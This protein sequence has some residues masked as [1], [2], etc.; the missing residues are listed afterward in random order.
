MDNALKAWQ[1]KY[2]PAETTQ[3]EKAQ[4][5]LDQWKQRYSPANAPEKPAPKAAAAGAFLATA[6]VGENARETLRNTETGKLLKNAIGTAEREVVRSGGTRESEEFLTRRKDAYDQWKKEQI[7]KVSDLWAQYADEHAKF[8]FARVDSQKGKEKMERMA[9]LRDQLKLHLGIDDEQ[10]DDILDTY[11]LTP[12]EELNYLAGKVLTG[13]ADRAQGSAQM[14]H[15]LFYDDLAILGSLVDTTTGGRTNAEEKLQEVADRSFDIDVFGADKLRE[16]N[17]Q[18]YA[19]KYIPKTTQFLG[20]LAESAGGMLPA[21]ATG[22]AAGMLGLSAKAAQALNYL[23][24]GSGAAGNAAKQAL[25]EGADMRDAVQYGLYSGMLEVLTESMFAGIAGMNESALMD[26]I[27]DKLSKNGTLR[28]LMDTLG[29]G[30][31]EGVVAFLEPYIRRA[32]IDPEAAPATARE[33]LEAAASGVALSAIMNGAAVATSG[34]AAVFGSQKGTQE[35]MILQD[36][37]GRVEE[38]TVKDVLRKPPATKEQEKTAVQPAAPQEEEIPKME[39]AGPEAFEP[40]PRVNRQPTEELPRMELAG[41]EDFEPAPKAERQATEEIP[42]MEL[43]GPEAF[44]TEK[45]NAAG[46]AQREKAR[47]IGDMLEGTERT[48]Y[49]PRELGV[50][51]GGDAALVTLLTDQQVKQIGLEDATRIAEEAGYTPVFYSGLMVMEDGQISRWAKS[52]KRLYIQADSAMQSAANIANDAVKSLKTVAKQAENKYTERKNVKEKT[53]NA[54]NTEVYLR[55]GSERTGSADTGRTVPA[56]EGRTGQTPR[57]SEQSRAADRGAA[58]LTYGK[59]VSTASLGL[60]DGVTDDSLRVVTGGDT[61]ATR[62]AKAI[63]ASHGLRVTLFAGNDLKIHEPLGDID[64]RGAIVG[65]RVYIRVDHPDYT[66]DQIMRHEAGHAR[67]ARGEIDPN[68]VRERIEREYGT[69]NLDELAELYA[70]AYEGSGMTAAEIWEEVI[71]DSLGDMNIFDKKD[72]AEKVS[73]WLGEIRQ[74]AVAEGKETT[75]GPPNG[76]Q[77]HDYD[78]IANG[79]VKY[80]LKH[81]QELM[82]KAMQINEISQNVPIAVIKRA[83][84]AR[85]A[86]ADIFNDPELADSLGLPPDIIGNTYIPNGSYSGTEENTTVCIRSIAADA[87]MDAV[88]EKLGRPLTVEDTIAISQEYW[89]YTDKP[90]CLYCYVAMDRKAHRE[91]MGS[92]MDQRDMVLEALRNGESRE[93]VYEKFLDGRKDTG[94]KQKRFAMWVRNAD[95]DKITRADL[96]S[97]ANMEKALERNPAL[98]EQIN[99]ALKY[100]QN[101]SWAKKRVAYSAYNGHIL[102]WKKRRIDSLNSNYGLRMYSFSD[103]SPAFILENMQMVT[104]AAVRNLKVLAYTKELDF[105]RI[106]AKTGMNINISVFGYDDGNGGVAMDAMQGA[107]WA[108]AQ[109]LREQYKNVG[110][111]FVATNDAQVNWALEQDWV[112]VVIPFHMVRTGTKVADHFGWKNYTAMSADTKTKAFDSAKDTAHILPPVHQNSKAKY[113]QACKDNN[114]TPRFNDWVDHPNYMKLVKETRQSEAETKP[115]QPVFDVDAAKASIEDMRKRGGYYTPIGGSE[116]NMRYIAGEIAESI[117]GK[118]KFSRKLPAKSDSTPQE[119]IPDNSME[120]TDDLVEYVRKRNEGDATR[121]VT[122]ELLAENMSN[123]QE[124][125]T[126][127]PT[128]QRLGVKV[129]NSIGQYKNVDQMLANARAHKTLVRERRKYEERMK[130]TAKEKN[131]ARGIADGI[132][133]ISEINPAWDRKVIEA[134]SEWYM[135]ERNF[136]E[137]YITQVKHAVKRDVDEATDAIFDGIDDS[138]VDHALVLNHRTATRNMTKMFGAEKGAQINRWLF[139]PVTQN[140]AERIRFINRQFDKVRTFEDQQG[141]QRP[142]NK[143]ERELVQRVIEYRV[144]AEAV[145]KLKNAKDIKDAAYNLMRGEDIGDLGLEFGLTFEEQTLTRN[146][147]KWLETQDMLETQDS[148]IIYNA[149]DTYAELFDTYYDAI[150]EFLA[151]HG[152]QPIGFIKGYVPHLQPEKNQNMLQKTLQSMGINVDAVSIP[153]SIA[154][155]TGDYKPNKKWN[156]YFLHRNSGVTQYDIVEAF[157]SYV[158]NMADVLYHT[159]DIMRIRSAVRYFRREYSPE[160]IRSAIDWAESLRNFSHDDKVSF[161]LDEGIISSPKISKEDAKESLAEF[162]EKQYGRI[163]ET[164]KYNNLVT[165]LDNYA[166]ILAG[167]QSVADRGSEYTLGRKILNVGNKVTRVFSRANVAGNISSALNNSAQLPVILAENGIKNSTAAFWDV[168]S[169]KLRKAAWAEE[170]DF[171]TGKRGVN[172]IVTTPGEMTLNVFY[173]PMEWVDSLLSTMAVRGAYLR[174]IQQGM[175]HEAAMRFADKYAAEV[176]ADRSKG[177]KPLAFD[178]KNP[179]SAMVHLFQVEALNSWEHIAQDLPRDIKRIA[180]DRGKKK[181]AAALAGVLTKMLV[182]AFIMNR[183]AEKLYGGTPAMFDIFGLTANF[184]ASGEG[185]STN[186]FL[187]AMI[188]KVLL[189]LFGETLFDEE[190][191]WSLMRE[192]EFDFGAGL[193]DLTYNIS[194]E[195]PFVRNLSALLGLGDETLPLPDV[196]TPAKDV[197]AGIKDRDVLAALDAAVKGLG[198]IIPGGRQAVKTYT[199]IQTAARGGKMFGFGENKKLQYPVSRTPGKVA[200]AVIFGPSALDS[201]QSYYASGNKTLT[202]K[203]TVA[204]E[205][206]VDNGVDEEEAYEVIYATKGENVKEID[207]MQI[208]SAPDD[209]D[210]ALKYEAMKTMVSDATGYRLDVLQEYGVSADQY[211][212][213]RSAML[214]EAEARIAELPEEERPETARISQEDAAKVL[215][216]ASGIDKNTKAII[217][218][219][220]DAGWSYKSNPYST[221]SGKAA[222][223]RHDQIKSEAEEIPKMELAGLD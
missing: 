216:A 3:N 63:A 18:L 137:L 203:E 29:E 93:A 65:N 55:E 122:P 213:L 182:Y 58:A 100:A 131:F 220:I 112:D 154:G 50:E 26:D 120:T 204:W 89:K 121:R 9:A 22:N 215:K 106:F 16:Y 11:K 46:E 87:L 192:N 42:K 45:T 176:M 97:Y 185:L 132:Y 90:E 158:A 221:T 217:W 5:A 164:H 208:M 4:T 127:G 161:L 10:L 179:L 105:V 140:E 180:A 60:V 66:A 130:A 119:N 94:D 59:T 92:Y 133:N 174:G 148:T 41:P 6:N 48:R 125:F 40:A 38:S 146:Y 17:E 181:A 34:P 2:K 116:E 183:L 73:E 114:L 19:D 110:C 207:A 51:Q 191:E 78:D 71:C 171:L 86:V 101:A 53:T 166:N 200:K 70:E 76:G 20:G 47:M 31:E 210:D 165:W 206:L 144:A 43:A 80:S 7:G 177:A 99:D 169:G 124:K 189:E 107:D 30:V 25:E 134:L 35:Q 209:W 163:E 117:K 157:E 141:K 21:I 147:V 62:K 28:F 77:K 32:T 91:F 211:V 64:A 24:F 152:Y 27:L 72:V 52:G 223:A 205:L 142:L 159:D 36:K 156:P 151:A 197:F 85:Q 143:Q 104:D 214:D 168:V 135:A 81:N 61:A 199:G 139:E 129:V 123:D 49:S 103:F 201:A 202:A 160:E 188:D 186:E 102:K 155:L 150:N 1:E 75:R 82:E 111:T 198:E 149:A 187:E 37:Y 8:S 218:Q 170:S 162:I 184:I 14:L 15:K 12:V 57:R 128:L 193:E 126:G 167:K 69:E 39:L 196:V 113:L 84:E 108:E 190:D 153:T 178:A 96:A 56:V 194:N 74:A 54:Q 33:I 138:K 136:G 13:G 79:E 67:I 175:N 219:M 88:A 173:K 145:E 109:K 68:T 95:K 98:K 172:F 212:T 222:K 115:V 83:A 23:S 195:I 118:P 44:E